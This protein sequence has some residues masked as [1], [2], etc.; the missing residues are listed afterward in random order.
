[1][2]TTVDGLKYV[3]VMRHT[4]QEMWRLLWWIGN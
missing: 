4:G 1:V 3:Y 2:L